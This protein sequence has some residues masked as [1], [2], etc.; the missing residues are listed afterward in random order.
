MGLEW[1]KMPTPGGWM[2]LAPGKRRCYYGNKQRPR[3]ARGSGKLDG[4]SVRKIGPK[5]GGEV[6]SSCKKGRKG[7]TGHLGVPAHWNWASFYRHLGTFEDL[8]V[9]AQST[10][11]KTWITLTVLCRLRLRQTTCKHVVRR[12]T[13]Q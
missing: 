2:G 3:L 1:V 6:V 12:A 9:I 13:L 7:L 5:E 10:F 11:L 8:K 4:G